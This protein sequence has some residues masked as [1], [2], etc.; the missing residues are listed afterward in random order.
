[1][2]G[3]VKQRGGHIT[4]YSEPD[5]GSAF[6]IYMPRA[7]STMDARPQP[8]DVPPLRRGDETILLVEDEQAVRQ[9]AREV[10]EESGYHILEARTGDEALR[11]CRTRAGAIDLVVSDLVMPGLS[12]Y[13]VV[14]G[15]GALRPATR[16]LVMSG[17]SE[18]TMASKTPLKPGVRFIGKP[19]TT[20]AL[21]R[22]VREVL[23]AKPD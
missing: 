10:L 20:E 14:E 21:Q 7:E 3:I 11:I 18:R 5:R 13:D 22:K 17:Y 4:V 9:V 8:T 1:V 15:I 19:F 16:F 6:Q 12:G 23:D 2:Y